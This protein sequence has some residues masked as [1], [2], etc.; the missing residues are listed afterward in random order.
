MQYNTNFIRSI[1]SPKIRFPHY[2]EKDELYNDKLERQGIFRPEQEDPI[3]NYFR[4]KTNLTNMQDRLTD[5][6]RIKHGIIIPPQNTSDLVEAMEQEYE[7]QRRDATKIKYGRTITDLQMSMRGHDEQNKIKKLSKYP[8]DKPSIDRFIKIINNRAF[9]KLAKY[10][11]QGIN[12]R[13]RFEQEIVRP[14]KEKAMALSNR[15]YTKQARILEMKKHWGD[16]F[17]GHV[18]RPRSHKKPRFW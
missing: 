4:S 9:N 16:D 15:R 6:A 8:V 18:A 11:D 10:L 17:R 7:H 13:M 1:K 12:R 5:H 3:L 2:R 14:Y